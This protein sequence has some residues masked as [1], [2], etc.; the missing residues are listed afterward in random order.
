MKSFVVQGL[1]IEGVKE[2]GRASDFQLVKLGYHPK[3][4]HC[5]C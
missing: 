5:V 3:E 2:S 4:L 1:R